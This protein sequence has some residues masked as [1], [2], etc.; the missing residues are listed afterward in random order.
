MKRELYPHHPLTTLF[1]CPLQ[2][3]LFDF[4]IQVNSYDGL[5]HTTK[6]MVPF[7]PANGN[8]STLGKAKGERQEPVPIEGKHLD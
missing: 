8:N 3:I 7:G 4:N 2:G 6:D 1:P 5:V